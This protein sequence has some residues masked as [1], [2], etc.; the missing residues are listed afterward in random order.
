MELADAQGL[1][2]RLL[3]DPAELDRF[4]AV[5][6]GTGSH[7]GFEGLDPSAV[8]RFAASLLS[9]RRGEV[10]KLLP[11]TA[12]ALGRPRFLDLFREH[13]AQAPTEGTK[14]HRDDAIAFAE[15]LTSA[16]VSRWISDLARLEAFPLVI[17]R[18]ESRWNVLSLS[19][20]L[21]DL[22]SW[23]SLPNQRPR[24]RRTWL[25]AFGGRVFQ[26]PW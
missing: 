5:E 10:A 4:L 22:L 2:V 11:R 3:T 14:R 25:V 19:F 26:F 8:S 20:R 12:K 6:S 16:G 17:H 9:K 23:E 18:G 24:T 21:R 13:A 1:M 7:A 15:F